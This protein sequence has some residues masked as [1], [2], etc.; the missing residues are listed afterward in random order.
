[1][2]MT[3]ASTKGQVSIGPG[4]EAS[5]Q[6]H[7]VR[8]KRVSKTVV[9]APRGYRFGTF[10]AGRRPG[11]VYA[12]KAGKAPFLNSPRVCAHALTRAHTLMS[13]RILCNYMT[14]MSM[15]TMDTT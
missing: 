15:N 9:F 3:G 1:M 12:K 14:T 6:G 13:V 2:P 5:R 7:A 4:P 10:R 11:G 8:V